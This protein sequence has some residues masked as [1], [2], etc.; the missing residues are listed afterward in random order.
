MM[1]SPNGEGNNVRTSADIRNGAGKSRVAAAK[2]VLG[3][4]EPHP[5]FTL[6]ATIATVRSGTGNTGRDWQE[7]W[8]TTLAQVACVAKPDTILRWYRKTDRGEVRRFEAQFISW[9]AAY[10][11]RGGSTDHQT[12]PG[13]RD[14]GL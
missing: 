1:D 11:S 4:G 10:Q 6:A 3:S 14:L 8:T 13:K 7:A 9:E 5:S 2:S 12:R